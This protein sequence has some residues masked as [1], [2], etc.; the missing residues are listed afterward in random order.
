MLICIYAPSLD[1]EN[2]KRLLAQNET[3]ES[4]MTSGCEVGMVFHVISSVGVFI[5]TNSEDNEEAK[6]LQ[7]KMVAKE[8][9][10][11]D[12]YFELSNED[13]V[14]DF[15]AKLDKI[16]W[17]A[18]KRVLS[19]NFGLTKGKTKKLIS[20]MK[21]DGFKIPN[22]KEMADELLKSQK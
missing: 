15:N 19:K 13:K 8:D 1:E 4:I 6:E 3:L 12:Y 16:F 10:Q 17:L 22:A 7:R 20:K 21:Q 18:Y 9:I 5:R 14:E 2:G 11:Y